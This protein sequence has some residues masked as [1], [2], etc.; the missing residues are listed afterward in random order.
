VSTE[1]AA[2]SLLDTDLRDGLKGQLETCSVPWVEAG[3][4][5]AFTCT[6]P[7]SR[8]TVLPVRPVAMSSVPLTGLASLRPGGTDHLLLTETLPS[9]ADNRFTGQLTAL[10][11][12]FNA[13]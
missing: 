11:Y 10:T 13:G 9:T 2:S 7:G 5:P 1:V 8:A 4:A 12:A 6:C 3:T